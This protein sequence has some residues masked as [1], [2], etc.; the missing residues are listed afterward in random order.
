VRRL[1][2]VSALLLLALAAPLRAADAV[3]N[4]AGLELGDLVV[5]GQSYQDVRVRSRDARSVF[6]THRGGFASARLRDLPAEA[7]QRLGFDPETAP[8]DL[9]PPPPTPRIATAPARPAAPQ[10]AVR[11]TGKLESL[12]LDYGQAPEIRARQTLQPE[13]IRHGLMVKNQGRRPSCAIFAI[14]SALEFQN[15]RLTGAVEQFSEDYLIWATRRSLGLVG[16]ADPLLRDPSTDEYVEDTGFTLPSVI[17]ALQTYGVPLIDEVP[18]TFRSTGGH[19]EPDAA[20]IER[21]RSRRMVFIAPLPGREPRHLIPNIIHALNAEFPV[22]IGLRWPH[23]RAIQA[24]VLS[25][26]RPLPGAAHAVT[27]VGYESKTGRLEDTQFVFKNS[28]GP[29]WGQGGYGRVTHAYLQQH[30]LDA[31]VLDV[32]PPRSVQ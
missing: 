5:G 9:P 32:R 23:E 3:P 28:Y 31:Y 1:P 14:V 7:Q 13:F 30:L 18:P 15:V 10:A 20:L 27:L 22:P 4:V 2:L 25:A 26:Q 8:P 19:S 21:A 12:F 29:R 16:P 17:S 6:F 24:G 11:S